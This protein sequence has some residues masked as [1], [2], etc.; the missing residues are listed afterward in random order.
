VSPTG[1]IASTLMHVALVALAI[2]GLPQLWNQEP[3]RLEQVTVEIVTLA[4]EAG[5]PAPEP[6]P[7]LETEETAQPEPEPEV[8][9][10]ELPELEPLPEIEPLP[11]LDPI[12][13]IEVPEPEALPEPEP[14]PEPEIVEPEPEPEPEIV[15]PEPEP[16]PVIAE[17]PVPIEKPEA[18]ERPEEPEAA[19]EDVMESLLL[20][21]LA[22]EPT[23]ET[24]DSETTFDD[25]M[26]SLDSSSNAPASDEETANLVSIIAQQ[27]SRRWNVLGG[28]ADAAG[29]L[30]TIEVA[31]SQDGRVLAAQV[32]DVTYTG[33]SIP[34]AQEDAFKQA[35]RDSA[36]RAV[37][38]FRD[39][40]F[41]NLPLDRYDFWRNM[42]IRFDP[43]QML[44]T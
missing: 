16:Q 37:N 8:A 1:I 17:A 41:L 9:E 2:I 12:E 36:L 42:I 29:L 20:D 7:E 30:V 14:L 43:S 11:E 6:E 28:A 35:A 23:P 25:V 44:R 4:D 39:H 18:P 13:E 34:A 33:D 5:A 15:E 24:Q 19:F 3:E 40:P 32:K 10:L 27:I 21:R 38:Y 26:A 22:E 31:L